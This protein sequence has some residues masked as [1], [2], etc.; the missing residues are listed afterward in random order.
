MSFI[1]L[2]SCLAPGAKAK[3]N[4][5]QPLVVETA[6]TSDKPADQNAAAPTDPNAVN[7]EL[8]P[9]GLIVKTSDEMD[10]GASEAQAKK[11]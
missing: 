2:P 6:E 10:K 7:N 8:L 5:E 3:K 11:N 4:K 1:L 9:H